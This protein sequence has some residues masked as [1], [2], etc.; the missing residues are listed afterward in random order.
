M[1]CPNWHR[2][3]PAI[4]LGQQFRYSYEE[5]AESIKAMPLV[6]RWEYTSRF[7]YLGTAQNSRANNARVVEYFSDCYADQR[8]ALYKAD[9]FLSI[10][11]YLGRHASIFTRKRLLEIEANGLMSV[12]PVLLRAVHC[13]FIVAA[14]PAATNPKKL[15]P[16]VRA[17]QDIAT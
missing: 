11:D 14:N 10:C 3:M 5:F 6:R 16:L 2:I 13:L 15:L 1:W 8:E 4:T 17:L 12:E 7:G 9:L